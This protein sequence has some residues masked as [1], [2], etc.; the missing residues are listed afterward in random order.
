MKRLHLLLADEVRL[1]L[2]G[3]R[4]LLEP[5]FEVVGMAQDGRSLVAAARKLR[6]DVILLEVSLPLLNGLD[7]ARQLRVTLPGAKLIFLTV[8]TDPATVAEAFRVGASGYVSKQSGA[9]EVVTAIHEA[10]KGQRY[11]TPFVTKSALRPV[12]GSVRQLELTA[13]QQKV[14]QLVAEGRSNK[15]IA[16]VLGISV[17]TV[18]FHKS[19]IMQRLSART[20]AELTKYAIR[21]GIVKG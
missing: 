3:L 7:A 16:A 18:E 12:L 2:E 6:P 20:T 21:H 17:K 15:E 5:E 4:K 8:R 14:L 9:S 13:R 19:G 10:L 11:R 1:F